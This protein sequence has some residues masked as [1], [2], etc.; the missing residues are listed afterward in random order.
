MLGPLQ[1]CVNRLS[2]TL[3]ST[4]KVSVTTEAVSAESTRKKRFYTTISKT[5]VLVACQCAT[6]TLSVYCYL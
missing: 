1:H 6:V 4:A 2:Q 3:L 5:A